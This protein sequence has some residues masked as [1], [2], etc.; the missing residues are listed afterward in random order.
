MLKSLGLWKTVDDVANHI[1]DTSP[2]M[3]V[4]SDETRSNKTDT[5]LITSG[6]GV[7]DHPGENNCEY[8]T[9]IIPIK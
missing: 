3:T 8:F 5:Q 9:S 7:S 4:T 6:S 2:D 1:P